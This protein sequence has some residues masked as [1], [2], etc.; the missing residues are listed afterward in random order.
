MMMAFFLVLQ[1]AQHVLR[2]DLEAWEVVAVGALSGG[3]AAIVTTPFNVMQ[4][5][6]MTAP[7]GTPVS[8]HMIILS[9]LYYPYMLCA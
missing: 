2:R 5:R 8:M 9:L 3:L 1:A 7:P 4:T 6:M